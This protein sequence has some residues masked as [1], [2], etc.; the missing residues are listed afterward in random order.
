MAVVAIEPY[1]NQKR[2]MEEM[3]LRFEKA[4]QRVDRSMV[5][6]V[7][8]NTAALRELRREIEDHR[9]EFKDEMHAQ[10]QALLHVLDRLNGES[11]PPQAA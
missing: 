6:H 7:R 8:E 4:F 1:D 9:G 2:F 3:I 11:G 10:R 5:Q